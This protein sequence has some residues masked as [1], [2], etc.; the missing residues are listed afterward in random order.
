M[1]AAERNSESHCDQTIN[2]PTK[3]SSRVW[4]WVLALG[5]VLQTGCASVKKPTPTTPPPTSA[6]VGTTTIVAI[7]PTRGGGM[8]LPQFL[9]VD[10][11]GAGLGGLVQRLG[12][13]LVGALDLQGRFPNLQPKPPLLEL[14]DPANLG[15]DQPPAI[16]AAAAV[17]QEEDQA[18]QKIMAIRYLATLGCG[19]CYE[20]VEDA[21]Y[22]AMSD[23][24]EEVR[25]EAVKA[26]QCRPDCGC[27]YCSSPSCCTPKIRK[28]LE[29][30]TTCEK[31][32]SARIRRMARL[33]LACCNTKPLEAEDTPRE[34]PPPEAAGSG[35]EKTASKSIKNRFED[36]HL[37]SFESPVNSKP[38]DMLLAEVNGEPIFESHVAPLVDRRIA[39]IVQSAPNSSWDRSALL[40]Y[41]LKK[42]IEWKLIEQFARNE[43]QPASTAPPAFST[44]EV[45]LWFERQVQADTYISATELAS[46]YELNAPRFLTPARVRWE[47]IIVYSDRCPSSDSASKFIEFLAARANGIETP[48]P[49]GFSPD[50]I[51]TEV[52]G[53][54]DISSQRATKY[55]DLLRMIPVGK[56]SQVIREGNQLMLFRILERREESRIPLSEAAETIRAE[57]LQ[58]RREAAELKL[59]TK[60]WSQSRVWTVF[61]AYNRVQPLQPA[62]SEKAAQAPFAQPTLLQPPP[63]QS[64]LP[65]STLPQSTLPQSTLPQLRPTP[66]ITSASSL[67][68]NPN[69]NNFMR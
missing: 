5:L 23:C 66:P 15:E 9:G 51:E 63:A 1:H 49:A 61:D 22:E 60:L 19:G 3:G 64:T 52:H 44:S 50:F 40:S 18:P 17:K 57:I 58:Q 43:V 67:N 68:Y 30:L 65:Q 48:P 8:T 62:I 38:N 14:T 31:E 32:P 46:S 11:V 47:R 56:T 39:E 24:T 12:S 25:F 35:E 4:L 28:R 54:T 33:A 27:R 10:K 21:L 53:W 34:G 69:A 6:N 29:Q 2:R 7:A 26:L 37:V 55:A 59:L 42:V 36:I 16:Q 13:R 41:E 45:R 20:K